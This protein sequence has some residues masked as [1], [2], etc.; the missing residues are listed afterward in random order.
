MI[1]VIEK[2]VMNPE[3]DPAKMQQLLDIQITIMDRQAK[4]AYSAAMSACQREMPLIVKN[5]E[6]TQTNSKYSKH[7]MICKAIKPIYTKHGFSLTF[8]E[9]KA[10]VEGE[11]RTICDVEHE[12]GYSKQYHIDLPK[13][14][15]GIKGTVNKTPIHAKGSTFSYGRRYLTLMVFDLATY[16]DNDG[17]MTPRISEEQANQIHSKLVENELNI[18]KFLKWCKAESIEMIQEKSFKIVM[19]EIDSVIKIREKK[20]NDNT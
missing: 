1:Q 11:I 16:D 13:D 7:E 5:A 3:V 4:Q 14:N 20:K 6:N 10:D 17:N 12:L 15:A 19:D 2:A 18:D 9:G 8:S